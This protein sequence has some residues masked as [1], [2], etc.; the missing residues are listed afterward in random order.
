MLFGDDGAATNEDETK[1]EDKEDKKIE[2]K[3]DQNRDD[4][5]HNL[6]EVFKQNDLATQV[7]HVIDAKEIS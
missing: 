5:L 7:L 2:L 1:K 6:K 4:S 3:S